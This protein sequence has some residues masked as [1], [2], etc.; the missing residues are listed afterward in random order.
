MRADEPDNILRREVAMALEEPSA[1]GVR[2]H[3]APA[4][5]T[6][7]RTQYGLASSPPAGRL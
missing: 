2:I 6:R 3:H 4:A 5:P 1:A 7:A